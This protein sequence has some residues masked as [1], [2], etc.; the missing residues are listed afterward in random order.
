[1]GSSF[2]FIAPHY[3][4]M[5]KLVFGMQMQ[6]AQHF[7]L[8]KVR[9]GS[10]VVVLGGGSGLWLD[11][12]LKEH[13]KCKI[14]YIESASRML[15]L[16]RKKS[17]ADSRIEFR[18][19]TE[20]SITELNHFDAVITFCYLDLFSDEELVKIIEKIKASVRHESV[21][22][23]TDFVSDRQW[24]K[25]MLKLMYSFFG[26]V[27]RLKNQKLPDWNR[28]LRSSGL[29]EEEREFF[30]GGFIKSSVYRVR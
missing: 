29:V 2:D 3:D 5:V 18:L 7:F 20:N 13:S 10:K 24:H 27:S 12:F 14:V 17:L 1:M 6:K 11:Q 22:L 25:A 16:A 21:W 9:D 23:A 26:L 28:A 30:Y 15:D 19:G 8:S 4:K